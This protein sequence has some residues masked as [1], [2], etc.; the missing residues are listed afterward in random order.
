MQGCSWCCNPCSDAASRA[1]PPHTSARP[2]NR[3]YTGDT[4]A[5]A[6]AGSQPALPGV[7]RARPLTVTSASR[8]PTRFASPSRPDPSFCRPRVLALGYGAFRPSGRFESGAASYSTGLTAPDTLVASVAANGSYWPCAAR[9]P[10]GHGA[11]LRSTL[12]AQLHMRVRMAVLRLPTLLRIPH[13]R[14]ARS[15]WFR[16]P[17]ACGRTDDKSVR[18][19]Q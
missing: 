11:A 17:T 9:F 7:S 3:R 13:T 1:V 19:D 16:T 10:A 4:H 12:R 5:T 14:P 6:R 15:A 2:L 18:R 8:C